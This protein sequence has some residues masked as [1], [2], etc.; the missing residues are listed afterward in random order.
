MEKELE[1]FEPVSLSLEIRQPD[2]TWFP[3]DL[4]ACLSEA[5]K[6][7]LRQA[8]CRLVVYG[9]LG[10]PSLVPQAGEPEQSL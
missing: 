4:A 6:E 7:T 3:L 5:A 8:P 10:S 2:G 9:Q 1:C